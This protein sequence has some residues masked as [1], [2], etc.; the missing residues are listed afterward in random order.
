[1]KATTPAVSPPSLGKTLCRYSALFFAPDPCRLLIIAYSIGLANAGSAREDLAE[2]L[3]PIVSDTSLSMDLSAVAALALG[4]IFVG[5]YEN[6]VPS[7]IIQTMMERDDSQLNDPWS[8]YLSLGLALLYL[9]TLCQHIERTKML[10]FM[11]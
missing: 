2:H 11:R 4:L 5:S 1:M 3:L 10:G 8:R 9:G 7:T 6:D